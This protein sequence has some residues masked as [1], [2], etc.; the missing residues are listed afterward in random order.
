MEPF[1]NYF[2]QDLIEK[3]A[4]IFDRGPARFDRK[5]FVTLAAAELEGLELKERATQIMH[6]LDQTLPAGFDEFEEAVLASLHKSEDP[7]GEGL[8]FDGSGLMGFAAWPITD[9]VTH[10]GLRA[11]ERALP[12][13]KEV[14]KR[15]TAEF[16]IRPFLVEHRDYTLSVLN[17]WV[18]DRSRHVR[19]LVSEGTRPRLPWGLRLSEFVADPA[20]ILPFLNALRDDKEDYVRRSVANSL[21]DIAKDHPDMVAEIAHDWLDGAS[22]NR[23]RL[24]RHACRTLLKA[25]HGKTLAA[26]GYEPVD[27]LTC[28]LS[29]LTPKVVFG[30]A[31][32][33][34]A[35]IKAPVQTAPVMVD[36][37]IHFAKA[38]GGT[39][40]KVFKWKDAKLQGGHLC[41][42]RRHAI[43]P[44]TTRRYYEGNHMLELFVNGISVASADFELCM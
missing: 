42:T 31:L 39:A 18:D 19:R 35:I 38:N 29:I 17:G 40:P 4:D 1:K 11:P 30:K 21:N 24:V 25:G 44:I 9:L 10:R 28:D 43:K 12:L 34:E 7:S 26:F 13:L 5:H 15:F 27:G 41:A 3:T 16:A 14:T 36:Y 37:A 23:T 2:N 32:E 6:A 8:T 20:P 22:A 33:F